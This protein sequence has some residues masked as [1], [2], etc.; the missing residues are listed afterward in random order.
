[1]KDQNIEIF[2]HSTNDRE[3][4]ILREQIRDALMEVSR[5]NSVNQRIHSENLQLTKERGKL[6][7]YID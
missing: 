7:R 4:E 1:M 2:L 5:L 3:K 6:T